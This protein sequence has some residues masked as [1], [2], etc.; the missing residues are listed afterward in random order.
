MLLSPIHHQLQQSTCK[1]V[2]VNATTG[3]EKNHDKKKPRLTI[4]AVQ[5]YPYNENDICKFSIIIFFIIF[6]QKGGRS[7]MYPSF[8]RRRE[9]RMYVQDQASQ[10]A[11][12]QPKAKAKNRDL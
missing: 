9:Q 7:S 10:T 5:K 8:R 4:S 3:T 12:S 11:E 6:F 1:E 2:I